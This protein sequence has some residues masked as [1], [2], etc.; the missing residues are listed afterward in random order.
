M[1]QRVHV[2]GMPVSILDIILALA[3]VFLLG[4]CAPVVTAALNEGAGGP[5]DLVFV[6]DDTTPCG[7]VD[8]NGVCFV[9][10]ASSVLGVIVVLRSRVNDLAAFD[11]VC[12]PVDVGAQCD[13]GEVTD[14]QF[15][16]VS[17][18]AVQGNA[19][20]RL[21]GSNRVYTTFATH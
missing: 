16:Y 12:Y 15:I 19:T 17:G 10:N 9:P 4:G 5:A 13:L 14:P 11:A 8:A 20:Y 6:L 1:R 18:S 3:V 21:P 7:E 2:L